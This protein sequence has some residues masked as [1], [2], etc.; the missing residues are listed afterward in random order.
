MEQPE[1]NEA[2]VVEPSEPRPA[3]AASRPDKEQARVE[4][5]ACAPR[6]IRFPEHPAGRRRKPACRRCGNKP[7]PV[8][9]GDSGSS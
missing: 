4:A 2:L 7:W 9:L 1:T 6:N 8:F 5:R 3:A